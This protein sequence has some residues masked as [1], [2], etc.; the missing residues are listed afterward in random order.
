[1]TDKNKKNTITDVKDLIKFAKTNGAKNFSVRI[2][3]MSTEI[4]LNICFEDTNI[5]ENVVKENIVKQEEKI[6]F[7]EKQFL[8]DLPEEV[9]KD[10]LE[11]RKVLETQEALMLDPERFMDQYMEGDIDGTTDY[12]Y[13]E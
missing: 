3:S 6:E 8:K 12:E 10:I 1:M 4:D 2:K 13:G 9:K 7:N 11:Q 5:K